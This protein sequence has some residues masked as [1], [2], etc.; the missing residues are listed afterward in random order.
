M[1]SFTTSCSTPLPLENDMFGPRERQRQK[2]R[3]FH[4]LEKLNTGFALGV[5]IH[6]LS[7]MR[8][9]NIVQNHV[10]NGL[11]FMVGAFARS[12]NARSVTRSLA[13]W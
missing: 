1:V 3:E 11:G 4:Q 13:Q 9:G 5:K 8:E 10:G 2:E 12:E 6:S 7:T